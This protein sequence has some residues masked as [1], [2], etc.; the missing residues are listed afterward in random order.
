M[1]LDR[2][3][4]WAEGCQRRATTPGQLASSAGDGGMKASPSEER[5]RTART[6][7]VRFPF[8]AGPGPPALSTAILRLSL[9]SGRTHSSFVVCC[10]ISRRTKPRTGAK[11]GLVKWR[12]AVACGVR[13]AFPVAP[14]CALAMCGRS[15]YAS[16]RLIASLARLENYCSRAY[17]QALGLLTSDSRTAS[18]SDP[19]AIILR[20]LGFDSY[21]TRLFFKVPHEAKVRG[22]TA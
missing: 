10:S 4:D 3:D 18:P 5:V 12:G 19:V 8:L 21:P 16:W 13:M 15:G 14:S 9:V 22:R 1:C 17:Q 7:Q 20:L 2:L 6:D 11:T